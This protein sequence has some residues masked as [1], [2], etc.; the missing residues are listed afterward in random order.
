[1]WCLFTA[2]WS[3]VSTIQWQSLQHLLPLPRS[4]SHIGFSCIGSTLLLV[5]HFSIS[6]FCISYAIITKKEMFMLLNTQS[7][8]TLGILQARIL[9][10]VAFPFSRGSSQPRDQ[11]QIS[12]PDLLHCRQILYQLSYKGSPKSESHLV[13]QLNTERLTSV[14]LYT[15]IDDR[16][17]LAPDVLQYRLL[18]EEYVIWDM[19]K[20]SAGENMNYGRTKGGRS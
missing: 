9:K 8:P 1:M 3:A 5:I 16:F 14:L 12:N 15:S 17:G 4:V 11:T 20:L 6:Q 18:S 10:W 19:P 7:W 13:A 2:A